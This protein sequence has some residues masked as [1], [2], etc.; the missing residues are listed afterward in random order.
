MNLSNIKQ[1]LPSKQFQT[2]VLF[3]IV[4][5]A[6]GFGVFYLFSKDEKFSRNK[7]LEVGKKTINQIVDAD[8]DSDGVPDW[9]ENL[10]G[11]DK[12][13]KY[14][15][16]EEP[17]LEYITN[18]KKALNLTNEED[19]SKLT[20]TDLF[21][22]QFFTAYLALKGTPGIEEEDIHNFGNALGEKIV[23][24]L[25]ENA[26]TEK[27][28]KI[29]T[30]SKTAEKEYFNKIKSTFDIYR[31]AGIG[32][33]VA[34]LSNGLLRYVNKGEEETYAELLLIGEA[35]QEFAKKSLEIE[36]PENLKDYHLDIINNANNTG[37]SVIKM[38]KVVEDPIVG[39]S[40]LSS[41]QKYSELLI[42]AVETLEK[43]FE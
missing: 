26:Y 20:E 28:L 13:K 2:V 38:S 12:N 10:W 21:A 15:F 22:R 17:D 23:N 14:T 37:I 34:I 5:I 1:Y 32:D 40:A 19:V 33:E 27:D 11:T 42:K 30:Q 16:G 43:Y 41:Y 8:T 36:V 31:N 3:L 6:I 18:K 29:K 7:D 24:P 4:L 9:E 35:Y 39:L 25:I